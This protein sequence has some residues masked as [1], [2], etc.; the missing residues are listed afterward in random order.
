MDPTG[1][2][3]KVEVMTISFHVQQYPIFPSKYDGLPATLANSNYI[4]SGNE[5]ALTLFYTQYPQ[6]NLPVNITE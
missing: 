1:D 2:T 4:D 5:A 6:D 3:A